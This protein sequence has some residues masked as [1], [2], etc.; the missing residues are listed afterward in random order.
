MKAYIQF[1]PVGSKKLWE[2]II[3]DELTS[4][5]KEQ[6][7]RGFAKSLAKHLNKNVRL[8]LEHKSGNGIYYSPKMSDEKRA[9]ETRPSINMEMYSK[10][11]NEFGHLR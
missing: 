6:E 2:D 3:Q 9:V 5:N 8:V 1:R 10:L 4:F 11:E 7:A